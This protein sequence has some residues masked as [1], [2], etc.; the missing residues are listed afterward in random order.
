[1]AR[2]ESFFG[3]GVAP[4]VLLS[5][6]KTLAVDVEEVVVL[7]E[8]ESDCSPETLAADTV[9]VSEL[10]GVPT[11]SD[12]VRVRDEECWSVRVSLC[13]CSLLALSVTDCADE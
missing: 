6:G 7:G 9:G 13:D 8:P 2:L 11:V 1:M 3:V 10:V 4:S 12:A 5:D